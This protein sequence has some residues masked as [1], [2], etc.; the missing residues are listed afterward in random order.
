[1]MLVG[2]TLACAADQAYP[3]VLKRWARASDSVLSGLHKLTEL[4]A[5]TL[6]RVLVYRTPRSRILP[7][8]SA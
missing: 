3:S 4:G 1:M 5:L 7:Q 6:S 2:R 8:R